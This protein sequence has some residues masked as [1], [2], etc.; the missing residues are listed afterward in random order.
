[1]TVVRRGGGT[2]LL[3]PH[4]A[5]LSCALALSILARAEPAES[6]PARDTG[7]WSIEVPPEVPASPR[8]ARLARE[9][10]ADGGAG[11]TE[12]FWREVERTGAPLIEPDPA[13][14]QAARDLPLAAAGLDS[15]RIDYSLV[16]FLWRSSEKVRVVVLDTGLAGNVFRLTLVRLPGTDVWY[17]TLPARNDTRLL[18]EF[19]VNDSTYPYVHGQ[20]V[21]WPEGGRP[22]PLNPRHWDLA[23]PRV[24][25]LLE[26]PE[27]PTLRWSTPVDSVR[28]GEVGRF[29]DSLRSRMLGNTRRVFYYRPPGYSAKHSPYALLLFP[30]SYVSTVPLPVVMDNLIAAGRIAPAVVVFF[31]FPPGSQS[32]ETSCDPAFNEFLVKDERYARERENDHRRCERERARRCVCGV[33]APGGVRVRA[34][35]VRSILAKLAIRSRGRVARETIRGEAEGRDSVLSHLRQPGKH[36]RL[37]SLDEQCRVQPALPGRSPRE[38]IPPRIS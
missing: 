17:R 28:H 22:D 15:S 18:Y 38:G 9:L 13:I 1:L 23:A 35:A 10:R 32:R 20:T 19:S 24:L 26:L 12:A 5:L 7:A 31:D 30:A 21:S 29:P 2:P 34:I 3:W 37:R 14:G 11:A 33:R 27:A 8:I 6:E 4:L 36:G 16:T 25:S